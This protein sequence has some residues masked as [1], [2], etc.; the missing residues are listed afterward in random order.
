MS[1][2]KVVNVHPLWLRLCHWINAI[3]IFLMILS[4]WRIYD[5]SP[6]FDFYFPKQYTLGDGWAVPCSGTLPPCGCL[7]LMAWCI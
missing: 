1:G 5:A 7:P 3:A 4:G 6:L 2:A